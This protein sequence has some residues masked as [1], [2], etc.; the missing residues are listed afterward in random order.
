M[1]TAQSEI[2]FHKTVHLAEVGRYE[3]EVEFADYLADFHCEFHDLRRTK[4]F[5]AWH[6]RVE[7]SAAS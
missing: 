5:G 6:P 7:D 4:R 3:D 1:W 2:A